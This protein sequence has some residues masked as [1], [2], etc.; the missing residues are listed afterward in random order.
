MIDSPQRE[1]SYTA[2]R[3]GFPIFG[4][5]HDETEDFRR[6]S[7]AEST[8]ASREIFSLVRLNMNEAGLNTFLSKLSCF[9]TQNTVKTQHR[10]I[11]FEQMKH[12]GPKDFL[13]IWITSFVYL[14]ESSWTGRTL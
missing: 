10:D 7:L 8:R 11:F 6:E 9:V 3:I 4:E 14:M 1:F 13:K 2:Q 5:L 12:F